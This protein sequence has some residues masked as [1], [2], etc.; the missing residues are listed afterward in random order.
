MK[1]RTSQIEPARQ[2]RSDDTRELLLESALSCFAEHGVS[3]TSTTMISDRAGL[4]RGAYL[5]HFKSRQ[6]LIAAAIDHSQQKA[7][8]AIEHGIRQLFLN[9]DQELFLQIWAEALP[10]AFL[11][12]YEMM[13]L[14]RND[15]SL[16][17]E[18]LFH[19]KLFRKKRIEVLTE[20]FGEEVALAEAL[21]VLEGIADFFRGLKIM[22]IVR[23]KDESK[24]VIIGIAPIFE[25]HL[26]ELQKKLLVRA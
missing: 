3:A 12:G 21:P 20:L 10:D 26:V 17:S 11:A 5:H 22:E 24:E 18:W 14:S 1:R 2:S 19:S 23:T 7:M 25:A 4:S 16:L 13:L 9:P 6:T 15:S 8:P